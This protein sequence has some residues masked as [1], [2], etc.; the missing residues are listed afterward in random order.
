MPTVPAY[1]AFAAAQREPHGS[2]TDHYPASHVPNGL[3]V[4]S[5]ADTRLLFFTSGR[6][7]QY[8][9]ASPFALTKDRPYLTANRTDLVGRNYGLVMPDPKKPERVALIAGT[10]ASTLWEDMRT[11]KMQTDPNGAIERHVS[12][13][14]AKA[15]TVDDRFFSYMHD[16]NDAYLYEGRTSFANAAWI[17]APNATESRL[18]FNVY[19]GGHWHT[20]VTNP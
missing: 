4:G 14:D 20:I 3:V 13:Y 2:G 1:D 16:G 19:Q 6:V 17:A 15:N 18:L 12:I 7:V 9:T 8:E 11:S 10:P 5:D